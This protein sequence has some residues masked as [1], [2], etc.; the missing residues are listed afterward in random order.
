VAIPTGIIIFW[1]GT[2]ATIPA[3]WALCNGGNGTPDLRSKFVKGA[4]AGNN[5]GGTG[6]AATHTHDDH[7][8][9]S[10]SG[11][12]IPDHSSMSHGSLAVNSHTLRVEQAVGGGEPA[13]GA[14]TTTTLAHSVTQATAHAAQSHSVTQ[15]SNH[16]ARSH[17][18]PASEPVYYALAYVMKL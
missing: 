10:H 2:I 9:R 17:D 1:S 4:A 16:A 14:A 18:T 7:A 6:G 5:P 12:S 13:L 8:A 3:G 11:A 15:S